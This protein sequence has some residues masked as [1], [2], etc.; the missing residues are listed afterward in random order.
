MIVRILG[1]GQ[2]RIPD[3]RIAGLQEV[4]EGLER[5]V[6]AGDA[7][8]F[9]E[10]LAKLVGAVRDLGEPLPI[11]ELVPSDAVVPDADT[12]L[13]EARSLLSDEG[14]IPD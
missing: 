4:D 6:E 2:Y 9:S 10:E 8:A 3:D 13:E 12:T 14:L 5:A 7:V 1:E 11:E